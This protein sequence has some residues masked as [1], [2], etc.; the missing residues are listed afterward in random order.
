MCS[1]SLRVTWARVRQ[2]REMG[3]RGMKSPQPAKKEM[4]KWRDQR[5]K[6]FSNSARKKTHRDLRHYADG[7]A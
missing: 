2:T 3:L 4:G 5:K 7:R 6:L 1:A